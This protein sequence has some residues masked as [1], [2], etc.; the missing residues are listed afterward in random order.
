MRTRLIPLTQV[1]LSCPFGVVT[2]LRAAQSATGIVSHGCLTADFIGSEWRLKRPPDP[3]RP[4]PEISVMRTS[5]TSLQRRL[6]DSG[7]RLILVDR[8]TAC[9]TPKIAMCSI[10]KDLLKFDS[11]HLAGGAGEGILIRKFFRRGSAFTMKPHRAQRTREREHRIRAVRTE[12]RPPQRI[13]RRKE[14]EAMLPLQVGTVRQIVSTRIPTKWGPVFRVLGFERD[15]SN[16][17]RKVELALAIVLGDPTAPAPLL[18]IHSQCFT[19]EALGS[20][21]C[22]CRDQ[23]DIAMAAIADE[24]RG[25]VI[26]EYQAPRSCK[27]MRS[28]MRGL[29]QSTP[30]ARSVSGLTNEI[31]ACRLQF[32]GSLASI[33]SGFFRTIPAR[34]APC[35]RAV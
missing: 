25:L 8:K 33:A 11:L 27:P 28:R 10:C 22:D 29:T 13:I 20:L 30:T 3:L 21:R 15:V 19:G 7:T 14:T 18:R 12:Q 26:Y 4:S 5:T 32:C 17:S 24:G 9:R 2:R 31:S 35:E 16:G 6:S 34:R 23:L 1:A